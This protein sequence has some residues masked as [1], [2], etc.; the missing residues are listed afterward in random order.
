MKIN[1]ILACTE[2]GLIG[3]DRNGE[4]SLPWNISEDMKHFKKLTE[5]HCVIV[6]RKTFESFNSLGG[7]PK[8]FNVVITRN[9]KLLERNQADH[10]E[11]HPMVRYDDSYEEAVKTCIALHRINNNYPDTAWVIGGAEI[12]REAL[13]FDK[14]RTLSTLGGFHKTVVSDECVTDDKS[15]STLQYMDSDLLH[16]LEHVFDML[17]SERDSDTMGDKVRFQH[18]VS[19]NTTE[20]DEL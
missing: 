20:Q 15:E 19:T 9:E 8:R 17:V 10:P 13:L 16:E 3:V 2:S 5:N 7:L 14:Y 18:Y 6:G 12:Y 11:H 1:M 4:H